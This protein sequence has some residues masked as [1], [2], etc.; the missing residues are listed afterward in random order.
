MEEIKT[1]PPVLKR[2]KRMTPEEWEEFKKYLQEKN[3]IKTNQPS[4][5]QI[6][7][8]DIHETVASSG[9]V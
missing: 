5:T 8:N 3:E 6:Q 1:K 9:R 7:Q 4:L 2:Q